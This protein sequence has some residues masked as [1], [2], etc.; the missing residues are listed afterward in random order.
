MAHHPSLPQ[1]G[2][3]ALPQNSWA[4]NLGTVNSGIGIGLSL[5]GL[6]KDFLNLP[7]TPSQAGLWTVDLITNKI[8]LVSGLLPGSQ[9]KS[10]A[11]VALTFTATAIAVT[12]ESPLLALGAGYTL[13]DAI[14]NLQVGNRT[15]QQIITDRLFGH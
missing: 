1:E 15:V 13:G 2:I 3:S 7:K 12:G 14:N 8:S 4:S 9:A 6:A 11:D 10:Y 5:G